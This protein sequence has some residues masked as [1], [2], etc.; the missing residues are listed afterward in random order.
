MKEFD[1][2]VKVVG[3]L[4]KECPWDREQTHETLKPYMVEELNESLEAIDSKDPVRMVDELGDQLLHIL[5]HAEISDKFTISDIVKNITEKMI[6][7]HPHV[8]YGGG[9]KTKEDVL[10]KWHEIKKLEVKKSEKK[11]D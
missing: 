8:F 7:R 2:L 6:R 1:R 9:A 5:M 3:R 10:K 11:K 4:R